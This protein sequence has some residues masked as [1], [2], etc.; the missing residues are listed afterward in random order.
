MMLSNYIEQ[1][2]D[3]ASRLL[4]ETIQ[5]RRHLHAHP[6]LSFEEKETADFLA[7]QL[8]AAGIPFTRNWAGHG[9]VAEIRGEGSHWIALRGDMDA[10][11]IQELTDVPYKSVRAGVMHACGHDVHSS[12]LLGAARILHSISHI[13]PLPVNIRCIFQP[14]EEKLPGGASLMIQEGV[15]SNPKPEAILAQHVYPSMEAGKVGIRPGLYMA[16]TDE[17]YITIRGKG[18]HA[19]MP[20]ECNDVVLAG[21]QVVIALQQIAARHAPAAIP[22]VLSIGKC[23]TDGGATNVLP[24]S[25]RLEGTFRT[26]DEAWRR[27]AYALIQEIVTDTCRAYGCTAEVNVERGYPCLV[28]EEKLTQAVKVN[29]V[30]YLGE[31]N[32][33]DLPLRMTGEDFSFYGHHIPACFYRLGTRNE[34][35]NIISAV[36]TPTFDVEEAALET[37]MGLMAWLAISCLPGAR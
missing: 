31:Q 36:H 22:T 30:E 17:L 18:G 33:V 10:L 34:A 25:M 29:M 2:R 27:Q 21:S 14:G 35:R 37:G 15:L 26:M 8:S 20:H 19:A 3:A 12:C 23:Q 5:I 11:P 4:P 32:V 1:I 28:N 13:R 7:E 9:I 16:S 24:A 6:E